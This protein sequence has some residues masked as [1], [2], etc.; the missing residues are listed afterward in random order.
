MRCR[1]GRP[2]ILYAVR[3]KVWNANCDTV[4]FCWNVTCSFHLDV[5]QCWRILRMCAHLSSQA[6]AVLCDQQRFYSLYD[7]QPCQTSVFHVLFSAV[8][9]EGLSNFLISLFG[10]PF[11]TGTYAFSVGSIGITGV[12]SLLLTCFYSSYVFLFQL[13]FLWL[14]YQ[15]GCQQTCISGQRCSI[16]TVRNFYEAFHCFC[17]YSVFNLRRRSSLGHGY[18]FYDV[19]FLYWWHHVVDVNIFIH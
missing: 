15:P 11:G 6:S 16:D 12:S 19:P 2:L 5:L 7:H 4:K 18:L 9:F 17:C 13:Y 10:S 14:F 1:W 8:G 3:R